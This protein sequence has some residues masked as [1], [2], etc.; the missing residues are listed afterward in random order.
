MNCLI[1]NLFISFLNI[2][3]IAFAFSVVVGEGVG[4]SGEGIRGLDKQRYVSTLV[5]E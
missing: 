3:Y 2:A 4:G 1:N 5:Q